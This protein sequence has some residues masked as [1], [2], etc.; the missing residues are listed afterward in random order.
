MECRYL[1]FNCECLAKSLS[2]LLF[3]GFIGQSVLILLKHFPSNTI[4]TKALLGLTFSNVVESFSLMGSH[5]RHY[6]GEAF[7]MHKG[8]AVRFPVNGRIIVDAAFFWKANPNYS[9]PPVTKP[10]NSDWD[11]GGLS[12]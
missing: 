10:E 7:C 1:D 4:Q 12:L 6:C 8:D 11:L 9:R 5:H 3:Q 2:T